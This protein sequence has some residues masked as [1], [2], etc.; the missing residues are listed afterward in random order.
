MDLC[1]LA[2]VCNIFDSSVIDYC[3]AFMQDRFFGEF[4]F[5]KLVQVHPWGMIHRQFSRMQPMLSSLTYEPVEQPE[6]FST[7]CPTGF[8][9]SFISTLILIVGRW[10]LGEQLLRDWWSAGCKVWSHLYFYSLQGETVYYYST[11]T[12]SPGWWIVGDCLWVQSS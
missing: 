8:C 2:A 3:E 6:D 5:I 4:F 7:L 9:C 1:T 12:L 11:T 10:E